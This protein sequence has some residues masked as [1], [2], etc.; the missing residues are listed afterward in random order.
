MTRKR[1]WSAV[2]ACFIVSMAL[3]PA[4]ADEQRQRTE[5]ISYPRVSA[6]DCAEG[7]PY[8]ACF[9]VHAGDTVAELSVDDLVLSP[10]AASY[11]FLDASG[12]RIEDGRLC[13]GTSSAVPVGAVRLE[14]QFIRPVGSTFL[15]PCGVGVSAPTAGTVTATFFSPCPAPT[16]SSPCIDDASET[17]VLQPPYES[18]GS[19]GGGVHSPSCLPRPEAYCI[20][21]Q[22]FDAGLPIADAS[23]GE[24]TIDY[25][26]VG[27]QLSNY[28]DSYEDAWVGGSFQLDTPAVA[29]KVTIR[30]DLG[31]AVPPNLFSYFHR[32]VSVSGS[33][34]FGAQVGA[35]GGWGATVQR[36]DRA[37][38]PASTPLSIKVGVGTSAYSCLPNAYLMRATVRSITIEP[39][40]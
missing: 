25:A 8:S 3:I 20:L 28:C 35:D 29:L 22:G 13:H 9:D 40:S 39:V 12:S 24:L 17:K 18:A 38:F 33:S 19:L 21:Q 37:P 34:D 7:S 10:I 2:L 26:R 11:V 27:F 4:G 14:V 15:Q 1:G 30:S 6:E 16:E 32:F 36:D 5:V 31:A 23:T